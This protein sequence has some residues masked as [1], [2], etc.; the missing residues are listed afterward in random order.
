MLAILTCGLRPESATSPCCS[1]RACPTTTTW[2]SARSP[3]T[4]RTLSR[5]CGSAISVRLLVQQLRLLRHGHEYGRTSFLGSSPVPDRVRADAAQPTVLNA[6]FF[7]SGATLLYR[8]VRNRP[9]TGPAPGRTVDPPVPA[10][11]VCVVRLVVEG[12]ALLPGASGTIRL[13][14]AS[15][16]SPSVR[17][18]ALIHHAGRHRPVAAQRSTARAVVLA[19]A[20]ITT[21][22][23]IRIGAPRRDVSPRRSSL[24]S[25]SSPSRYRFPAFGS[26]RCEGSECREIHAG[27]VFTVGHAYKLMD[28]G[29]H[30]FPARPPQWTRAHSTASDAVPGTRRYE[31]PGDTAAR[32]LRSRG[33]LR[34]CPSISSGMGCSS[35]A[36]G[37][38]A[39][40]S[41]I[42]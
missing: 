30:V 19:L 25:L 37:I 7:V 6:L 17:A 33:E 16:P 5:A 20:G 9:R 42:R 18:T 32:Q 22:L 40:G 3:A 28:D 2:P 12:I 26:A 4:R 29:F 23:I 36:L 8:T 41:A 34:F 21:D 24:P 15:G 14:R 35:A 31:F 10:V 27:H 38:V 39:V 11:A 13:R 1:S